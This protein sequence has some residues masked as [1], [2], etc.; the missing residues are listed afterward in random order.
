VLR[1]AEFNSFSK[2]AQDLSVSQPTLT[3][4]ISKLESEL[5][6]TL[7]NR[8]TRSVSLTTAGTDFVSYSV[9]VMESLD[10][11]NEVMRKH[12][13]S[14]FD[15]LHIGIMPSISL[16][17]LPGHISR[18]FSN[19]DQI[20]LNIS[21]APSKELASELLENKLDVAFIDVAELDSRTSSLLD[22]HLLKKEP[23]LLAM[24][25]TSRFAS[26]EFVNIYDLDGANLHHLRCFE[27]VDNVIHRIFKITGINYH[28][29]KVFSSVSSLFDELEKNNGM[30]FVPS[31]LCTTNHKHICFKRTNVPVYCS[32]A[33]AV[34]KNQL[35][36]N[37]VKSFLEY[38]TSKIS[39]SSKEG[40]HV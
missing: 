17:N 10:N 21:Q 27:S 34:P 36:R 20:Y 22:I 24:S 37:E 29:R 12:S 2:A 40:N 6:V 30:A 8:T 5:G 1:V 35:S 4:Q 3:Q 33:I 31:S 23:I 28:I 14:F 26:E 39:V 13:T 18:Y 7:F 19:N 25:T 38:V 11:L 32:L 15:G 9:R 16:F